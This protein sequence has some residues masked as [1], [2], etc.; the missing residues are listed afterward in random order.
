MRTIAVMLLVAAVLVAFKGA[1]DLVP[2]VTEHQIVA[3]IRRWSDVPEGSGLVIELQTELLKERNQRKMDL[4]VSVL[5]SAFLAGLAAQAARRALRSEPAT[6]EFQPRTFQPLRP[7]VFVA[8]R[9]FSAAFLARGERVANVRHNLRPILE[10]L[11]G[12]K[13]R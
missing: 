11:F 6:P 9:R 3:D 7:A 2:S 13:E 8:A 5:S 12:S 4:L 10:R 1:T